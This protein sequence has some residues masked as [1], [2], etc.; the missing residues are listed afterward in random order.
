[1]AVTYISSGYLENSA[2]DLVYS[3][4]HVGRTFLLTLELLVKWPTSSLLWFVTYSVLLDCEATDVPHRICPLSSWFLMLTAG[5]CWFL[6]LFCFTMTI[7]T[8]WFNFIVNFTLFYLRTLT[9]LFCGPWCHSHAFI[10]SENDFSSCFTLRYW[11]HNLSKGCLFVI[12]C[13]YYSL[14]Y[15]LCLRLFLYH[16]LVTFWQGL[17]IFLMQF[18]TTL[19]SNSY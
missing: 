13:D 14:C 4:R 2:F 9:L 1:M 12:N 11:A 17:E 18:L 19:F 8:F 6:L 7:L 5:S 15:F 16:L 10:Q 3:S